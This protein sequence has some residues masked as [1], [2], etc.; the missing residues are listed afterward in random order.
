M[1][2]VRGGDIRPLRFVPFTNNLRALLYGLDSAGLCSIIDSLA[3]VINLRIYVR[4]YPS[5]G[6]QFIK[7]FTWI[8]LIFFAIV[9]L[10]QLGLI[11]LM[12]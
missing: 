9:V 4:E 7:T 5:Q 11:L 8:S 3:N 1:E 10:P 2:G 6:L 12:K